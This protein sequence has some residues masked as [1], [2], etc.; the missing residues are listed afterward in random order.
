VQT[1][2]LQ[3]VDALWPNTPMM[4]A[5]STFDNLRDNVEFPREQTV[6]TLAFL[7]EQEEAAIQTSTFDKRA[8]SP[9]RG[10]IAMAISNKLLRQEYSAGIQERLIRQMRNGMA[11]GIENAILNGDGLGENPTGVFTRLAG[12]A[13]ELPF[14]AVTYDDLVDMEILV[15]SADVMQQ[16]L[17]YVSSPTVAGA[18]KKER[19]DAGSGIFTVSYSQSLNSNLTANGYKLHTTSVCPDTSI[20]F[21]DMK[22]AAV[23]YWGAPAI[24]VDQY[25]RM[26]ASTVELYIEQFLD[27]QILRDKAFAMS[28]NLV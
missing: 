8:M 22:E 20:L 5:V 10:G 24:L 11:V 16:S 12:G 14:T 2:L 1:T 4:Q 15:T 3:Y 19:T 9:K 6:P 21:G 27:T 26:K 17:A 13:Q 7:A 18:M 23:G 28:D 25:S